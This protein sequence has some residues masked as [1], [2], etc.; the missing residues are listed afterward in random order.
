MARQ[1]SS[2][3]RTPKAKLE[4]PPTPNPDPTAAAIGGA[5]DP[6]GI[7]VFEAVEKELGLKLVKQ[8]R[9]VPVIVMDHVDEEPI[10]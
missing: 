6:N 3:N 2:R 9:P 1:S 8:R 10:Q 7:S 5:A 4:K